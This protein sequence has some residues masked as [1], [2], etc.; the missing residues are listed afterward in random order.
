M[1]RCIECA[2]RRLA[3]AHATAAVVYDEA[4]RAFVLAWKEHGLRRL[5][6]TAAELVCEAVERPH[7][8]LAFVA[9]DPT[10]ARTRGY[11]P[12]EALARDLGGKWDLPVLP[13]LTRAGTE[14][15][16]GLKLAERRANVRGAFS[17]RLSPKQIVLVDDVYTS[18]ATANAAAS[19]LRRAGAKTVGVITFAR[20][21]RGHVAA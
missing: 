5:A 21:V 13:L 10:R 2:G 4:V 16:R 12:A 14:R 19:A 8:P 3:F 11:R 9:S 20:A 7:A 6:S 1:R 15:Q 17:A 18:G